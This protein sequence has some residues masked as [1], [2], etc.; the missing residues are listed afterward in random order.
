M[1]YEVTIGIPVFNTEMYIRRAMESVLV[2]T[3][4][5][6]E[7]LVYDDGCTDTSIAIVEEYQ[8]THLRGCDIHIIRQMQNLGIGT[9]RNRILEEAQGKYL[10]YLDADDEIVPDT[11]ERLYNEA[12]KINAEL[13]YGS[14][15]RIEEWRKDG[16][17]Y[18][19]KYPNRTF[20]NGDAFARFVYGE[21][22]VIQVPVWNI[23]MRVEFLKNV[24]L[25]FPQVNF[26]EDFAATM[27]LPTQAKRVGLVS[28][29]TYKYHCRY[30]SLSHFQKRNKIQKQ[31]IQSVIV[32]MSE[33]KIK[34]LNLKEQYYFPQIYLKVMM[35][36]F[37]IACS[38]LRQN[39]IIYPSYSNRE[40]RD[41]LSS[42][43]SFSE[44]VVFR[45]AKWSNLILYIIGILPPFLA[46]FFLKLLAYSRK[47]I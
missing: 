43:L 42:P 36:H 27:F 46:V 5:S 8:K 34:C 15:I 3:H 45:K 18:L 26:W 19:F 4:K 31:E 21:Y 20:V 40:I 24:K 14:H 7:I 47:L 17:Y 30:G 29:I 32:A 6:I 35:T 37:Y 38:I 39:I 44:I 16:K 22:G 25:S 1:S 23:L 13:V 33:L 11:I 28:E 9:A 2:Q 41:I 10:Y 12:E